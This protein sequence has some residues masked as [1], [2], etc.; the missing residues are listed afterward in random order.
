MQHS[1]TN[2]ILHSELA[3]LSGTDIRLWSGVDMSSHYE[4]YDGGHEFGAELVLLSQ[5][6]TMNFTYTLFLV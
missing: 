4:D 2:Y 5:I 6:L 3:Q 1:R